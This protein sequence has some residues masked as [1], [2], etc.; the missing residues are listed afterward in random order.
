MEEQVYFD[1][2]L[3][4]PLPLLA[5]VA[6]ACLRLRASKEHFPN[7]R[8]PRA[9]EAGLATP[10]PALLVLNRNVEGVPLPVDQQE[11]KIGGLDRIG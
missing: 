5:G 2:G 4:L 10:A 9:R 8:V 1:K 3:Q 7:V 11:G 6:R